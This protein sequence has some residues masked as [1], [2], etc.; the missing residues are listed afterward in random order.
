MN[1]L[2]GEICENAKLV[3]PK[4]FDVHQ[5]SIARVGLT[6]K[7]HVVSDLVWEESGES[8]RGYDQG[9]HFDKTSGDDRPG[10]QADAE[11]PHQWFAGY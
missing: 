2:S 6:S 9:R 3:A 8:I 10:D 1:G 7:R 5:G 4:G 11:K